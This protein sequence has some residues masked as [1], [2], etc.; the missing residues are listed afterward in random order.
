MLRKLLVA[1]S[2][3]FAM[4]LQGSAQNRADSNVKTMVNAARTLKYAIPTNRPY[5]LE[6]QKTVASEVAIIFGYADN[7]SAC[8]QISEVLISSL[9]VGTFKC[10]PVH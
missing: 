8:E 10:Y 5:I 7:R 6:K 2:I 1:I 9:R 4:T 3:V